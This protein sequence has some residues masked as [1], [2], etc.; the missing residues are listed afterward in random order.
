MAKRKQGRPRITWT[1]TFKYDSDWAGTIWE[2]ATI[3][4]KD[5]DKWKLFAAQCP[6]TDWR[7]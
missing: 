3:L 4:A 2:E 1:R 7:A 5:R 6:V